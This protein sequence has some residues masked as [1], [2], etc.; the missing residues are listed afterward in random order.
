MSATTCAKCQSTIAEGAAFCPSC[1]APTTTSA[2]A[3]SGTQQVKFD[4]SLLNSTDRIVGGATLVLFISFFLTWFSVN[5]GFGTYGGSGL[6]AH[7]YLY[8]PLFISIAVVALYAA[9]ALGVQA[10]PTSIPV[11]QEQ[12]MLIAT[13]ISFVLVLIGF[14]AKPGGIG[15]GVGW[16]YGAF[17]GLVAAVVAVVPLAQPAIA[18]RRKS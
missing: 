18:A 1:G 2:G 14:L 10:F 5:T 3:A 13:V 7:G 12:A 8:I 11:P 9:K 15:G 17:I 16:S 6:D 4:L